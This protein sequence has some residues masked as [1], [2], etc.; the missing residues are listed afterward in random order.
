MAMKKIRKVLTESERLNEAYIREQATY[1]DVE[2]DKEIREAIEQYVSGECSSDEH[3]EA[4]LNSLR[5]DEE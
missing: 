5:D 3:L 2:L 1:E 4:I